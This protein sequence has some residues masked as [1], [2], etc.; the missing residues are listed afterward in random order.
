MKAGFHCLH[1]SAA[2]SSS[3]KLVNSS[4][5]TLPAN[6]SPES[7]WSARLFSQNW[8]DWPACR[9][10]TTTQSDADKIGVVFILAGSLW[11]R[12]QVSVLV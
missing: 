3:D 7:G 11:Q 9:A 6:Q 1:F 4:S 2:F 8:K 12:M 10:L 5:Q